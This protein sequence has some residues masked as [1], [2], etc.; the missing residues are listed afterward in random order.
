MYQRWLLCPVCWQYISFQRENAGRLS[1]SGNF[2]YEMSC[3]AMMAMNF[4]RL[5][6]C[7]VAGSYAAA[8]KNQKEVSIGIN[9]CYA[10]TQRE[11]A[12]GRNTNIGQIRKSEWP[13][14]R[15]REPHLKCKN[16]CY[17][18]W[19]KKAYIYSCSDDEP[20]LMLHDFYLAAPRKDGG[21][22]W[23]G[24][25]KSQYGHQS[26]TGEPLLWGHF[27]PPEVTC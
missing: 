3:V 21:T 17:P 20:I 4:S 16:Y 26:R 18:Q 24:E 15:N 27:L 11:S 10:D 25:K 9:H 8:Q 22:Q 5:L 13:W 14:L 7:I 2:I 12:V 6:N 1:L 19:L 23:G